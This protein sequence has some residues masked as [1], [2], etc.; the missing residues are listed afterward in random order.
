CLLLPSRGQQGRP[1]PCPSLPTD[2]AP[3]FLVGARYCFKCQPNVPPMPCAAASR[4]K[5]LALKLLMGPALG[6]TVALMLG[7]SKRQR[8]TSE[9]GP[10]DTWRNLAQRVSTVPP[11]KDRGFCRYEGRGESVAFA[12]EAAAWSAAHRVAYDTNI[13]CRRP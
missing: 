6:A 13:D 7:L 5:S 10:R 4:I 12:V 9:E 3:T 8:N 11:E 1:P 2:R